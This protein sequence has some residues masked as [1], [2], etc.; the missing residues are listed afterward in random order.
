MVPV[1]LSSASI[2]TEY[3]NEHWPPKLKNSEKLRSKI[4]GIPSRSPIQNV[5][6]PAAG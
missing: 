5:T 2:L 6:R 3:K 4:L 1:I